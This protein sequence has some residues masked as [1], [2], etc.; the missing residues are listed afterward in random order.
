MSRFCARRR[1]RR[2]VLELARLIGYELHPRCRGQ[3]FSCFY[4]RR[5]CR[6]ATDDHRYRH[7]S[8]EHSR[9]RR[10]T[11]NLRDRGKN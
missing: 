11:A 6:R 10:K 9:P 7:E 4:P 8:P 2:S 1:E 5:R 3:H